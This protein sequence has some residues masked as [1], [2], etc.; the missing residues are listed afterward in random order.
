[1]QLLW[2]IL[3]SKET[4]SVGFCRT[5][6]N[7]YPCRWRRWGVFSTINYLLKVNIKNTSQRCEICSKLTIET[8]EICQWH[9][10]NVFIF[11][12]EHTSHL[13]LVFLL[14]T[15]NKWMLAVVNGSF[16]HFSHFFCFVD[17]FKQINVCW[18]LGL[19]LFYAGKRKWISNN[20]SIT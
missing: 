20:G 14:L 8:L 17:D 3:R 5:A 1:M 19:T 11:N 10:S 4:K 7:F 16:Q 12:F 9:C 2:G 15:L 18:Q 13:Y 6:N